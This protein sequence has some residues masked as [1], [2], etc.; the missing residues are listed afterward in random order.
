MEAMCNKWLDKN[1]DLAYG[2]TMT[3]AKKNASN[4]IGKILG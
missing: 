4:K 3:C 2:K 1:E